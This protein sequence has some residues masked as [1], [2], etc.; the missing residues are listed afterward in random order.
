MHVQD[1]D[2]LHA[3]GH[4][5]MSC[6]GLSCCRTVEAA[7]SQLA[8]VAAEGQGDDGIGVPLQPLL[9]CAARL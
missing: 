3:A 5:H 2:T 1:V 8:A 6:T 4:M 7:G 9:C